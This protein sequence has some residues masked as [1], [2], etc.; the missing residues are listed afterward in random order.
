M[1]IINLIIMYGTTTF[2]NLFSLFFV[3]EPTKIRM[4]NFC[5]VGYDY[6][7]GK[8]NLLPKNMGVH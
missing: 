5:F 4:G 2:T 3:K 6:F 8:L 7:E 1:S